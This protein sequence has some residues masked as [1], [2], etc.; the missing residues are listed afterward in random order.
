MEPDASGDSSLNKKSL[1]DTNDAA[2]DDTDD[3]SEKDL[4]S[5]SM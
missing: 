5:V 3:L 1:D 4:E 2:F